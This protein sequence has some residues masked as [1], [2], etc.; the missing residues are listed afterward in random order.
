MEMDLTI[1]VTGMP[2]S[3]K[4]LVAHVIAEM[5][6]APVYS[7]G[8]VVR[9]EVIRRGLELT[10]ANVER[11]ATILRRELGKAAV[12]HLLYDEIKN[13]KGPIVVDGLRS[14][15]EARVLGKRGIL[16]IV[17]VHA[18][19]LIRYKRLLSRRRR[20][21][22]EGWSDLVLRDTKNLEFGIGAAIAMADYMIVNEGTIE[23][24]SA[25]AVRVAER[26]RSGKGKDCSGVGSPPHRERG[27]G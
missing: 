19:P 25:A 9:R 27:E 5:L 23:E 8:D 2:G 10:V 13:V 16:C 12:A 18:S 6:N 14:L 22:I 7:M 4:S 3:G 1:A 15:D 17:A 26:I 20:D 21:D 24:A 11:V